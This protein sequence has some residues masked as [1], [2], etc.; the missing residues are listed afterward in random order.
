[1]IND[2]MNEKLQN[3]VVKQKL[4]TKVMID[5]SKNPASKLCDK[6][7]T[8][9]NRFCKFEKHKDSIFCNFHI[10]KKNFKM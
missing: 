10:S 4:K 9:K 6:F 8:Q 5:K 1:M 2:D 3:D 7:L